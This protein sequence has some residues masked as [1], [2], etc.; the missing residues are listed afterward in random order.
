MNYLYGRE[1]EPDREAGQEE[2]VTT[3]LPGLALAAV[4]APLK[5]AA[6]R[7]IGSD[8]LVAETRHLHDFVKYEVQT[9][10]EMNKLY[11]TKSRT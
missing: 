11:A 5:I 3:P 10:G 2:G 4:F 7:S 6:R 8:Q 9:R 1:T